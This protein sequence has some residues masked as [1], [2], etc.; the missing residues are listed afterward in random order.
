[1]AEPSAESVTLRTPI[2]EADRLLSVDP[3]LVAPG[4]DLQH[5]AET[6][7]R[8]PG[9]RTIAVVDDARR[10]LGVIPVRVLV[11]DI[12]LKLVPEEF[13]GEIVGYD[14]VLTYAKHVGART[15]RDIMV[16]PV[17]VR[18]DEAVRDAFERMHRSKLNGLP[19]V[20]EADRV[21][22]YVDQLEL[23]LVWVRA[24]GLGP[25][26]GRDPEGAHG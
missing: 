7:A 14:Q 16:E 11:N 4:D 18:A 13:L 23:L 10:L 17:S 6:A 19:I 24:T 21:I 1:M 8:Q 12:F 5:V 9:A 20:D 3:I 26:L 15:A 25:L 22:G 2:V